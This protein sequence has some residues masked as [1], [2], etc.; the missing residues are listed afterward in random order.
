[1]R[2]NCCK[3]HTSWAPSVV[4]AVGA[5]SLAPAVGRRRRRRRR[6]RGIDDYPVPAITVD[7]A[8][9]L[10]VVG[11]AWLMSPPTSHTPVL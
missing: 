3:R 9:D 10:S 8:T 2:P 11:H 5:A 6:H 1:M 7:S 4:V